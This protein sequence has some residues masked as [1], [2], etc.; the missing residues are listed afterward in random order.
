MELKSIISHNLFSISPLFEGDL[1][2]KTDKYKLVAEIEKLPD[3]T[4]WS[5]DTILLTHVVVNFMSKGRMM[6]MVEYDSIGN[7]GAVI[8]AAVAIS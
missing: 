3:L 2:A 6:P 5:R 7:L 1:P 4:K 8:E